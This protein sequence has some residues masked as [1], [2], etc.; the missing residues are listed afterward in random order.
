[1]SLGLSFVEASTHSFWKRENELIS[2]LVWYHNFLLDVLNRRKHCNFL[3]DRVIK[4]LSASGSIKK[5]IRFIFVHTKKRK[6]I[7]EQFAFEI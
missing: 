7:F 4:K 5:A 2:H 1:M 6:Q 3:G